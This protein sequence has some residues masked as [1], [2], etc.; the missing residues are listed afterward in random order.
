MIEIK[1]AKPTA[2]WFRIR[3]KE[4]RRSLNETR[5]VYKQGVTFLDRWVQQ[6]FKTEGDKVGGW[7][8]LAAGGRWIAGK[9]LDT[10]ASILQD[11]GI[12]RASFVP[13]INTRNAGIGSDLNYAKKHDQGIGVTQRRILPLAKE[14]RASL[15]KIFNDYYRNAVSK[16]LRLK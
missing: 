3:A 13:F 15:K 4:A 11:K 1:E 5:G 10:S 7:K 16:S 6:N 2:A 9:G 12:L 8:P 14:V